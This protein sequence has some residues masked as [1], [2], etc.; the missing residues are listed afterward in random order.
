MSRPIAHDEFCNLTAKTPL[1]A[2]SGI[3]RILVCRPTHSLGNTLLLTPLLRELQATFPGAEIDVVTRNPIGADLFGRFPNVRH[4]YCLPSRAFRR[5]LKFL[6]VLVELRQS[7]YDLVIDP[8]PSSGTGRALLVLAR[9]THK[10]GFSGRR[11]SALTHAVA[12]PESVCHT[13][14]RPLYLLRTALG[15]THRPANPTLDILLSSEERAQGQDILRR[16]LQSSGH[17]GAGGVIGVFANATGGKLL[18]EVWWQSLLDALASRYPAHAIVEI[19]P[20]SG[21]SMLSSR[22]PTFYSSDVR[23]I[24]RVLSQLSL[25]VSSDCG[26][27]HLACASDVPVTGIFSTTEPL[28]WGPYGAR[29]SVINARGLTA[30]QVAEQIVV[31]DR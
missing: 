3:L 1:L 8:H 28:E 21:R 24:A 27:M 14:Q 4:V 31:R 19:A 23:R 9:G 29:D 13:G 22:Y 6:D 12:V 18:P 17:T 10:L 25:F 30:E 20:A 15:K 11:D 2:T 26:I 7:H 5:P 16:L